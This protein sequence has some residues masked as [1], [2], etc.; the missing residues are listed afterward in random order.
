MSGP[1]VKRMAFHGL[2]AAAFFFALNFYLLKTDLHTS[3]MWAI[4]LGV[5]AAG[6]AYQQAKRS[7][8]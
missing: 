8:S 6:L 3:V 5:F 4:G 7:G 2:C 1:L